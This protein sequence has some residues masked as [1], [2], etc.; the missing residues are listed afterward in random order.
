MAWSH[1]AG[2]MALCKDP[3]QKISWAGAE[4]KD[5]ETSTRLGRGKCSW[6]TREYYFQEPAL[7]SFLSYRVISTGLQGGPFHVNSME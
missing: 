5:E 6:P 7:G 4:I 3:D 1:P 2:N